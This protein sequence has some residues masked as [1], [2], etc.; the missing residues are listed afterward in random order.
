MPRGATT[1]SGAVS[2]GMCSRTMRRARR[3][4]VNLAPG[5]R[6]VASRGETAIVLFD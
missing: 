1:R 2:V 4:R 3:S 5:K 6:T